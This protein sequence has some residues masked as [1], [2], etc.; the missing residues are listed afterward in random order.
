MHIKKLSDETQIRVLGYP[1][2]RRSVLDESKIE[3][4]LK[5]FG[6]HTAPDNNQIVELPIPECLGTLHEELE[7]AVEVHTA[8]TIEK[9]GKAQH[10]DFPELPTNYNFIPNSW[11]SWNPETQRWDR[12]DAPPND[13]TMFLDIEGVQVAEGRWHPTCA[14]GLLK[15]GWILWAADLSTVVEYEDLDEKGK[16]VT[17]YAWDGASTIPY[18]YG[19][20]MINYNTQYDRSYLSSEYQQEDT[21]NRF[22]DLMSAWIVCR[23][24]SNQQR[25]L[26]LA[27]EGLDWEPEWLD[28][29][30]TNSLSAVYEFCF[31]HPLDKGVRDEIVNL[32]L[33]WVRQNMSRVIEYCCQDVLHTAQLHRRLYP[34]YLNHRP[35]KVTQSGAI[36]L[37][38][39]WLPLDAERFPK[40]YKTAEAQYQAIV[41]RTN[42]ELM[43]AAER[44]YKAAIALYP[45]PEVIFSKP[46]RRTESKKSPDYQAN[47]EF[48]L[49]AKRVWKE[50]LDS[51]WDNW[52]EDLPESWRCLDWAPNISGVN[53]GVAG[54]FVKVQKDYLE[55]KL[56]L[57]QRFIPVILGITWKNEQLLWGSVGAVD[58]KGRPTEGWYTQS[59]GSLPHPEKR[60]QA[61]TSVFAKGFVAAFEDGTLATNRDDSKS[62]VAAKMSTVNWI[63]LRKRVAAIR[64]ESPEGFPVTLPQILVNGTVTGRCAD[65]LWQ[66]ASNP[67]KSR[68]GTELKS[69]ITPPKGWVFV[70]ADI[71]SQEAWL[72]GIMGDSVLGLCASTPMGFI[73]VAGM[74]MEN[75]EESTDIHSIMA[76]ETGMTRDNTKTRVYGAIY[77]QGKTGDTNGLLKNI[78]GMA[79][80][81]AQA[82]SNL[83]INKFKGQLVTS[84]GVLGKTRSYVGGLASDSFNVMEAIADS[85]LPRTPLFKNVLS[86]SL[87]GIKDFKPSRVNWTIQSSGVDFRDM[88]VL[89]V[90]HFYHKLGVKGKLMLT[91]HDEIRTMVKDEP[92]NIIKAVHCIQL[93]QLY[94]RAAFIDSLGLDCIPAGVAWCSAVDVDHYCLRKDPK[95]KQITPSQPQGIPLGYTLTPKQLLE[96]LE[97]SKV[98]QVA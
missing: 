75:L 43:E 7:E 8:R 16:K 52:M 83:F 56:T 11:Q 70:G 89:L 22:F 45:F 26:Y 6:L 82:N 91:I 92:Q 77:G 20:T 18:G 28:E 29:T 37:G 31:G 73:T 53:K 32:G 3:N 67:K 57:S 21:G 59:Y 88:L 19:N 64:T 95:D 2:V 62:L 25:P 79:L 39:L 13:K 9:I 30:T 36:L 97:P 66:V 14:V 81:E 68:I 33:P 93:A 54:W 86:K 47:V 12:R 85:K 10:W 44:F 55:S 48:N 46:E 76:K 58:G 84:D 71:D 27:K 87:A 50:S 17:K 40:Y 65:N 23:G 42:E 98:L 41:K 49:E 61:V 1:S 15:T 72:A 60:G 78:P 74:K 4:K 80:E 90:R 51:T 35:S 69:M 63:S 24:L 96:L 34:E 38:S 5:P 94:C